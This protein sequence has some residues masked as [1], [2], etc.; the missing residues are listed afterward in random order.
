MADRRGPRRLIVADIGDAEVRVIVAERKAGET[1]FSLP[2]IIPHHGAS[3]VFENPDFLSA[4]EKLIGATPYISVVVGGS[5]TMIRL[6]VLPGAPGTPAHVSHRVRQTLGVSD[7]YDV[8]HQVL[9]QTSDQHTVLTAAMPKAMV[10]D[11]DDA[12]TKRGFTPV[13]LIHTGTALANLSLLGGETF[14][15]DGN[16]A[17]LHTDIMSSTL[18][19][20]VNKQNVLIRQLKQGLRPVFTSITESYGLDEEMAVKLFNSGSFDISNQTVAAMSSWF[21]QIE[22]SL[23]FVARR[24]GGRVEKLFLSGSSL[25][26]NVLRENFSS[27]L[28]CPV[29]IIPPLPHLSCP[30]LPGRLAEGQNPVTPYL[31][32]ASE[33]ARIMRL[34]GGDK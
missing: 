4:V 8:V 15:R 18:S 19:V 5:D 26:L 13:S 33:G 10:D 11:L 6:M 24:M 23:D 20:R 22:M 16:T 2:S 1:F 21:H 34:S 31:I 17:I 7:D 28:G 12:L 30:S 14:D 29:D 3:T 27:A 32:A 9:D 25:G